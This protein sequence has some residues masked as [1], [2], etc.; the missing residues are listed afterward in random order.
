MS[1][2]PY[3]G[4]SV[5]GFGFRVSGFRFWVLGLGCRVQGLGLEDSRVI[6]EV[7]AFS[8]GDSNLFSNQPVSRQPISLCS[9]NNLAVERHSALF[10]HANSRM[11]GLSS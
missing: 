1:E 4:A 2:V 5:S 11:T 8:H 10:P 7:A 3:R 6:K 9:Q